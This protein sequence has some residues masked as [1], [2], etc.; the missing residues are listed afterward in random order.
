MTYLPPDIP[1]TKYQRYPNIND[2]MMRLVETMVRYNG[3]G[4]QNE[5]LYVIT[6]NGGLLRGMFPL[7]GIDVDFEP[8]DAQVVISSPPLGFINFNGGSWYVS[9]SPTRNQKQGVCL[10]RLRAFDAHQ[11]PKNLQ[12]QADNAF[13][14]AISKTING[15]YPSYSD[16]EIMTKETRGL[17]FD[18]FWALGATSDPGLRVLQ[19]KDM[20]VA[21]LFVQDKRFLFV[22]DFLTSSKRGYLETK[23]G[24]NYV[25][26]AARSFG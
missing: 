26:S 21:T 9:R 2:A 14:K 5:P 12:F 10:K 22:P 17:S 20:K 6:N 11:T 15:I 4:Y 3:N 19:Y 25:F 16:A 7:K 18:R 8:N 1:P 23:I 13:L 24:G